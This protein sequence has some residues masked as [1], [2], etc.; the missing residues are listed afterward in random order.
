[1]TSIYNII[2]RKQWWTIKNDIDSVPVTS[3]STN[4]LI[5]LFNTIPK[6]TSYGEYD[7]FRIIDLLNIVANNGFIFEHKIFEFIFNMYNSSLTNVVVLIDNENII[8]QFNP[9]SL[10]YLINCSHTWRD[11]PFDISKIRNKSKH[12]MNTIFSLLTMHY[13]RRFTVQ[14]MEQHNYI[15]SS[16]V[17]SAIEN[18]SVKPLY[19]KYNRK[20][21]EHFIYNYPII[22]YNTVWNADDKDFINYCSTISKDYDIHINNYLKNNNNTISTKTFLLACHNEC[23]TEILVNIFN[24]KLDF[25]DDEIEEAIYYLLQ[26][27]FIHE[28]IQLF[29]SGGYILKQK[30]YSMICNS[31]FYKKILMTIN[32]DNMIIDDDIFD[33]II[34]LMQTS[35]KCGDLLIKLLLLHNNNENVIA[36][37][38]HEY[39]SND[40]DFKKFMKTYDV[41]LTEKCLMSVIKNNN[42]IRNGTMKYFEE[43]NIKLNNIMIIEYLKI[44]VNTPETRKILAL[45]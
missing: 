5:N 25:T 15:L 28:I 31:P 10:D 37:C 30:H 40:K 4:D 6:I 16:D 11:F 3:I 1:M 18:T 20:D 17:L 26:F 27:K 39:S 12:V 36:M 7:K 21:Y 33:K 9:T 32:I 8:D 44:H 42:S 34:S 43:Q 35:F 24:N 22:N 41:K 14:F 45:L 29:I 38:C 23:K 2:L 13:G 19:S